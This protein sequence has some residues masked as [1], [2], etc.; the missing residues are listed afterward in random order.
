MLF[1]AKNRPQALGLVTVTTPG[2]PVSLAAT[3]IAQ[4]LLAVG[5]EFLA[6]KLLLFAA[7][8]NVGIIYV[9]QANMV[10]ATFFGVVATI[11]K[12]GF[13]S[14]TNNVSADV[15]QVEKLYIDADTANDGV[16]GN[17]DQN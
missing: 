7:P 17:A 9:G 14:Y 13:Y 2:T 1:D 5:D 11:T 3:L 15:L 12:G 16:F 8:A 4:G 6:N 10:R